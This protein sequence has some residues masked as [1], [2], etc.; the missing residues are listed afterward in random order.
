MKKEFRLPVA[1]LALVGLLLIGTNVAQGASTEVTIQTVTPDLTLGELTITGTGFDTKFDTV[2]LLGGTLLNIAFETSAVIVADLPADI[3]A[4]GYLLEVV[5]TG[6]TTR[7]DEF[8]LTITNEQALQATND[9]LQ[10]EVGALQS[11][12]D[13][14]QSDLGALQAVFA[15]VSRQSDSRNGHTSIV[16]DGVN[17]QVTNGSGSTTTDNGLG[18]LIVGYNT[19]PFTEDDDIVREGS[20]NLIVGDNHQYLGNSNVISGFAN[21]L[22]ADRAAIV[23]GSN[24]YGQTSD[25]FAGGN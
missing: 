5:V 20:H 17:L 11:E 24:I 10:A 18:N 14:L 6:G 1:V 19:W 25:S 12:V 2:V 21:W 13:T 22:E 3:A 8:D 9:A 23:G 4:G 15:G 16:F 7:N